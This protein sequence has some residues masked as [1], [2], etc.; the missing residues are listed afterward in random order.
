VAT[1]LLEKPLAA[2]IALIVSVELTGI[3]VVNFVDVVV[4]VVRSVV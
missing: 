2:A 1:A 4:G 3:A